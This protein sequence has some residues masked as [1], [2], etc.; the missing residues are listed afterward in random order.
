[1]KLEIMR[2]ILFCIITPFLAGP[3]C[4]YTIGPF[5]FYSATSSGILKQMEQNLVTFHCYSPSSNYTPIL[6]IWKNW[7]NA[8]KSSNEKWM[9]IVMIQIKNMLPTSN[10]LTMDHLFVC[11]YNKNEPE[12]VMCSLLKIRVSIFS[13]LNV[14]IL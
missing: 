7:D 3:F 10:N 5:F 11:L 9:M 13:C 12:W 1:M 14:Y 8:P 4:K 2:F 6:L